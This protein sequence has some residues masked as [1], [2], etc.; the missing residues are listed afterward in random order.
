MS[1]STNFTNH[2]YT[3]RDIVT[4]AVY[5][6]GGALHYVHLEDVAMKAAKLSPRRFCWKKYPDQINLEAVRIT[7]KN[8]LGL[9]NGRVSGSI[10]EGWMV[11]PGGLSWCL[12]AVSSG[13]NQGLMAELHQEIDRAKKTAAFSKTVG[14]RRSEVSVLEVEALIRV[15]DYFTARD[16]RERVL[17]LANA[18]VLDS[19]LRSILTDL[20]E[21]GFNELEVK[22]E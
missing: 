5:Q 17:A 15:N 14:G 20:R 11:T 4:M 18:A 19:E 13:D 7:L 1:K 10:R 16:R 3:N 9:P 12:A 2:G 8:E 21:Q 22:N 6:L